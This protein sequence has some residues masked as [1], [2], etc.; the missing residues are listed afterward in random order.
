MQCLELSWGFGEMGKLKALKNREKN[1]K[2]LE[3]LKDRGYKSKDDVWNV[4]GGVGEFTPD[5]LAGFATGGS[6]ATALGARIAGNV[7]RGVVADVPLALLRHG[8]KDEWGKET[9]KDVAFGMAGSTAGTMLETGIKGLINARKAKP[10]G[11]KQQKPTKAL[12]EP[13]QD[14][15][16]STPT[17]KTKDEAIAKALLDEMQTKDPTPTHQP[18]EKLSNDNVAKADNQDFITSNDGKDGSGASFSPANFIMKEGGKLEYTDRVKFELGEYLKNNLDLNDNPITASLVYLYK[19]HKGDGMYDKVT[20][21][22]RLIDDVLNSIPEAIQK[23]PDGSYYVAKSFKNA[24]SNRKSEMGDIVISPNETE[25]YIPHANA[26]HYDKQMRDT[27]DNLEASGRDV[28][29]LQSRQAAKTLENNPELKSFS[30]A[31]NDIIPHPNEEIKLSSIKNGQIVKIQKQIP[32]KDG[33]V[34][35]VPIEGIKESTKEGFGM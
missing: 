3:Y 9:A 15:S 14:S 22:A 23:R 34:S 35:F 26:K 32:T 6:S 20:D 33:S 4:S 16:T 24:N 21:V 8:H 12:S 27:M 29:S 13:K 2:T 31:N 19:H 25:N 18:I 10:Q 30:P 28:Q 11:T 5:V 7:A 17:P 1:Y